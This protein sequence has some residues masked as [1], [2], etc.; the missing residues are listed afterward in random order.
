MNRG[1]VQ[2]SVQRISAIF[3]PSSPTSTDT[4]GHSHIVAII[5]LQPFV[6]V[7]RPRG[8]AV[9]VKLCSTDLAALASICYCVN[10]WRAKQRLRGALTHCQAASSPLKEQRGEF[11]EEVRKKTQFLQLQEPLQPFLNIVYRK[12]QPHFCTPRIFHWVWNY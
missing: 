11:C 4:R 6:E 12:G 10:T 3:L 5:T 8:A 1:A 2:I 7:A 9:L